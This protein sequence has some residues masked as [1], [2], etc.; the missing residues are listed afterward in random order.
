M[1]VFWRHTA[2]QDWLF[3]LLLRVFLTYIGSNYSQ[4]S[5]VMTKL[6]SVEAQKIFDSTLP[7][8]VPPAVS[9]SFLEDPNQAG[10]I[11]LWCTRIFQDQLAFSKILKVEVYAEISIQKLLG[12]L[13]FDIAAYHDFS[14]FHKLNWRDMMLSIKPY[15]PEWH[16]KLEQSLP[17]YRDVLAH[18]LNGISE[19][20]GLDELE[21]KI[22]AFYTIMYV[23]KNLELFFDMLGELNTRQF[24]YF[25]SVILASDEEKIKQA[26]SNKGRLNRS[27][28][29][30]VAH[31]SNNELSVKVTLLEGLT[32]RLTYTRQDPIALLDIFFSQSEKPR[33]SLESY[34]HIFAKTQTLLKYLTNSSGEKGINILVYGEPGT[35][36]TQWVKALSSQI[37]RSLFEV[38]H[39]D[40]S[41]NDLVG[42]K[43]LAIFKLAQSALEKNKNAIIL[44]DEVEDVFPQ[45]GPLGNLGSSDHLNKAG[46]NKLLESNPVP[47]FWIS[48]SIEQIDSAYLR[49]FDL[50]VEMN[51]PPSSVRKTILENLVKG[52]SVRSNWVE[53]L[54]HE[55]TLVPAVIERAI[56]VAKKV[57]INETDPEVVELEIESL[58]NSTL[59]AQGKSEISIVH[60]QDKLTYSLDY[61]NTNVNLSKLV[62][63]LK[64]RQCARFCLYGLPG[65]G[66]S[67]FGRYIAKVLD[68]PLV[69]KR[70]SDLLS[71]FIGET[72]K[73]IASAF[74]LARSEGAI[75]QIDEA[76]SFL[77]A[78]EKAQRSWEVSQVNEMLTQ[79]ET[80]D[81]IFIAST[82]LVKGLDSASLR[83]FDVKLEFKP[84]TSEQAWL[85]FEQL[86]GK[87]SVSFKDRVDSKARLNNL[88]SLTPGD[89]AAVKRKFSL[90]L[91]DLNTETLLLALEE[92]C[93]HK[94]EHQQ[95]SGIGF[96]S[97]LT[98]R[99]SA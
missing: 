49:R 77:Q 52:L 21:S 20:I 13:G 5:V 54:A 57:H 82:N 32:E 83:R 67:E 38:N 40:K 68:K 72:E 78:R 93:S 86:L 39:E 43:R 24:I 8:L 95:S 84:L 80:F 26:L 1:P 11:A 58:I 23:N 90:A 42:G 59:I 16:A 15:I 14:E 2:S 46:M 4:W 65:T 30:R 12:F 9:D 28:I 63:G 51:T 48:N 73:N 55:S 81:G 89:F 71:P 29:I 27:G 69:I 53:Q 22:L 79:I 87:G 6:T 19:L 66:K 75:L 10:I 25:L 44:F 3:R 31:H 96:L 91:D 92:E 64:L 98:H 76:D 61:L 36:K 99:N 37:G 56:K 35:G 45:V 41:G 85:M 62:S 88:K 17:T 47:T 7:N 60:H 94:P 97:D 34:P 18:N 50:V 70:A 33:L 74:K